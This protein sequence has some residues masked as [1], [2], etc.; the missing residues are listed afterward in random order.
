MNDGIAISVAIVAVQ[1][2]ILSIPPN[3]FILKSQVGDKRNP[4]FEMVSQNY[5]LSM[6]LSLTIYGRSPETMNFR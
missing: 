1:S 4:E 5:A 3:A 6:R 2:G